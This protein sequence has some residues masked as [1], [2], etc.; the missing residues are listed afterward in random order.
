[1]K[2]LKSSNLYLL[3][4]FLSSS[5]NILN[6]QNVLEALERGGEEC[7]YEV[8][9]RKYN[10][11]SGNY[12]FVYCVIEGP[13]GRYWLNNNLGAEYANEKSTH[14]NPKQKAKSP[15]DHLAYGYKY[16]W[17]RPADGHEI[18]S[19]TNATTPTG[20]SSG[21]RTYSN[22]WTPTHSLFHVSVATFTEIVTWV[23][24][25][26]NNNGPFNLWQ[27]EGANNPCPA[28]FHVPTKEEWK[29]LIVSVDGNLIDNE[30][31]AFTKAGWRLGVEWS[32]TAGVGSSSGYYSSSIGDALHAYV[33]DV[34]T[35]LEMENGRRADGRSVRCIRDY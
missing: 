30:Q 18:V 32:G 21:T 13:D 8:R 20:W 10:D 4:L 14:F 11:A 15:I 31:L 24:N 34:N 19:Y 3:I 7:L 25:T 28:D 1:M 2:E 17:Q 23:N 26:L 29:T 22:T 9:D 6:A 27:A 5:C 33:V 35:N 12:K 16:Q